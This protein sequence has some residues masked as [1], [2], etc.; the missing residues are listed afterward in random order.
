MRA[1]AING[2]F[3]AGALNGV[4]RV[5]DQLVRELDRQLAQMDPAI[6]PEAQ[7]LLP[8]KRRWTPQLE[9]ITLKE[10]PLGHTQRWEQLLLPHVARDAVLI[11]LCN[12]APIRHRRKILM[13]HDA[14]F[15]FPDSSYPA[16]QRWGH[17]L[18][19]PLM[20]R[21]SSEVL[22]VSQYSRQILDLTGI[23]ARAKT[24]VIYNGVD[25][26][27]STSADPDALTR[28]SLVPFRYVLIFGS[29]KRY[30]N[31]QLLFDAFCS[32]A[33]KNMTL[34]VMG[35]DA[36]AHV[37]AGMTIPPNAM[38]TGRITDAELRA[39]Y[40]QA[41]CLAVPS[42]T[43]GFGIPPL[44]AMMVGCPAVV[45]PA[46]AMPE[47]CRDAAT[48]ADVDDPE[49]WITAI[50]TLES[51]LAFR[52]EK[53]RAGHLRATQF[54]WQVAGKKLLQLTLALAQR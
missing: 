25:H 11:N 32:P 14:Q 10:Q 22:T 36:A 38:F 54:T 40:E 12:L 31:V 5:A 3:Y 30:K 53:V 20:A 46:G 21:T 23:S 8:R 16:R 50:E 18:L 48:Y 34:V 28:F 2:K 4:H 7:L 43:E 37:A 41:I 17:R 6:R 1:I 26:M 27:L 29:H 51:K 35:E 33:L 52:L 49:E 42:R 24:Q 39:L 15:L 44:E 19:A 47:I 45:A 9:V 13:L